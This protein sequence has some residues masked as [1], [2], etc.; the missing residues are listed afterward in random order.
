[1]AGLLGDIDNA[2]LIGLGSFGKNFAETYYKMKELQKDQDKKAQDLE[3][4]KAKIKMDE[5][6]R[7]ETARHNK[8][9]E[10]ISL[11]AGGLM[12]MPEGDIVYD[13]SG[14]KAQQF[15][16]T[17]KDQ[18]I[19]FKSMLDR[20]QQAEFDR[21]SREREKSLDRALTER[22]QDINAL[23]E[24][25]NAKLRK[26]IEEMKDATKRRGQDIQKNKPSNMKIT[27]DQSD[28]S[29]Y[30]RR[31]QQAEQ[32]FDKLS[33]QGYDRT[34]ISEGLLSRF[35]PEAFKSENLKEEEQAERNFVNSILRRESGAA[36][37]SSEFK[38]AE[39]Q[40]FPR[41]GDSPQVLAQKKANRMQALE[42][43]RVAAGPAWQQ[44]GLISTPIVKAPESKGPQIGTVK[45][46]Y[47]F[48]GGNPADKN[49]WEKVK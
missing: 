19:R 27:K 32:I 8:R 29:I 48:I 41:A 26:E 38:S 46:G 43:M 5:E 4:Q 3:I 12:E 15:D 20:T 17:R 22:G 16:I 2:G 34:K 6:Q 14:I 30:G 18:D 39:A 23:K 13:P 47:K 7:A 33:G 31:I 24:E 36:I 25:E 9:Q 49:N 40:Y 10:N 35:S 11:V 37:S 44:V 45:N 28:A 42:G 21:L 1:M